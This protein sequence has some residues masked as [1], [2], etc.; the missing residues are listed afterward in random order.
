MPSMS[1]IVTAPR[2]PSRVSDR[3]PHPAVPMMAP[4]LNAAR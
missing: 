3:R 4:M 2:R 1:V